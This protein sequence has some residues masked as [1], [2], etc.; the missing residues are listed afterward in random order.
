MNRTEAFKKKKMVAIGIQ[1]IHTGRYLGT[2]VILKH[3]KFRSEKEI[4]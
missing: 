1:Y 3:N 4:K 2:K